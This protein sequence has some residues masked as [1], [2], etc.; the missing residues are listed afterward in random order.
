M[1]NG[2]P[3]V[4]DDRR[5]L[6]R[7]FREAR[8]NLSAIVRGE[9]QFLAQGFKESAHLFGHWAILQRLRRDRA[10]D[11][12]AV[13]DPFLQDLALDALLLFPRYPQVL[14]QLLHKK[15]LRRRDPTVFP[16]GHD[17]PGVVLEALHPL[18]HRALTAV[19]DPL[20]KFE[21]ELVDVHRLPHDVRKSQVDGGRAF[22]LLEAHLLRRARDFHGHP[23]LRQALLDAH[24]ALPAAR[25]EVVCEHALLLAF[26][27]CLRLGKEPVAHH[28][29]EVPRKMFSLDS[30]GEGDRLLREGLRQDVPL[31]HVPEVGEVQED[32]VFRRQGKG[33]ILLHGPGTPGGTD[34]PSRDRFTHLGAIFLRP[35]SV[36]KAAM[37]SLPVQPAPAPFAAIFDAD[38]RAAIASGLCIQCRGAKL[39]CGK[40]RCPILV[41]WDS[42][43]KTA[44]MIDRIDMDGSSPPGVFVGRIVLDDNVQ[45]FGPS[46][47]LSR[48]DLG[49]LKVDRNLDRAF[50]D[51]DLRAKE[52]VIDLYERRTPV[53]KIQRAFSV[54]AFGI[55][56]NRKFVPTR[57]SITAVDDT[58]GKELRQQVKTFPL[59]NEI[60]V[61]EAI[62]FD[63][64]FLVVLI[65]RP[66]R[67]ELIEAWYPNTLWNPLGR[68]IVMFGDH[69][70]YEGR[71]TYA[72][73]GG[74]WFFARPPGGA[75]VVR[76]GRQAATLIPREAAPGDILPGGG[77]SVRG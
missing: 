60:R 77:W 46:A 31:L 76:G 9:A 48:F 51:T 4:N 14:P 15:P 73:I 67:Y 17:G 68:D 70:A 2:L 34:N 42:M 38:T 20:E 1:T 50:S 11:P 27:V 72:C 7:R 5:L 71:T 39:L 16:G 24:G 8:F 23:D 74:G 6:D 21:I 65:P 55:E 57:W 56:K 58:I 18:V 44:P 43:M 29:I 35:S 53:S 52:A 66:W 64:R 12:R 61:H 10:I 40:A 32:P 19:V 47:P 33:R 36:E 3:I 26:D 62:G 22:D 25:G 75:G 59:I 63:D 13:L 30:R 28:L 41:R 37:L 49:T 69:E 54:G 45:P